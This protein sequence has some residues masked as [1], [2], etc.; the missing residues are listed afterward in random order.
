MYQWLLAVLRALRDAARQAPAPALTLSPEPLPEPPPPKKPKPSVLSPVEDPEEIPAKRPKTDK[1][2]C[3]TNPCLTEET[4]SP[5]GK[6]VPYLRVQTKEPRMTGSPLKEE[7]SRGA[8]PPVPERTSIKHG[9]VFS[10]QL[11]QRGVMISCYTPPENSRGRAKQARRAASVGQR[12][13]KGPQGKLFESYV[14]PVLSKDLFFVDREPLP[15]PEKPAGDLAPLT[16]AM[17]R[18]ISAAFD[19]GEPEDVLSRAFKLDVTRDDIST[20]QPQGWLNDKIIN[21]YMS[22]LVER[23]KKEGYPA[24][25]AFSTF[26]YSKLSSTSH[27]GVKKWTKGVDIFQHDVI[28]VPI[29]LTVHWTL[30]VIDLREKTIKYFDS[31]GQRG[32]QICK[33]LLKYLEEESK[34]KRNIELTASEWTLHSMGPEEH[35]PYFRRKMVWEIIHQQL[36]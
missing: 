26:F 28:L 1:M 32:D 5:F 10:P 25:Y 35:M 30:L 20:L 27:K 14:T 34:E 2:P 4:P 24:V 18:E 7:K 29:H 19:S 8:S 6:R 16:K 3:D 36:L 22:L 31:L 33:T 21:F 23:S 13:A 12:K 9:D 15:C 11:P 17:E